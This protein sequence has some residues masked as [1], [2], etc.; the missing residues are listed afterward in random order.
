M[1][2]SRSVGS[3]RGMGRRMACLLICAVFT[4][5]CANR[6]LGENTTRSNAWIPSF[7]VEFCW[8][9]HDTLPVFVRGRAPIYPVKRLMADEQGHAVATFTITEEGSVTD[10]KR[11]DASHPAFYAHLRAALERWEF[12]PARRA[13]KAVSVECRYRQQ[14]VIR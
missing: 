9:Y 11:E 12:E 10:I 3:R 2:G 13:G 14:Y 7:D 1:L 4:A 8:G 6:D 5:G